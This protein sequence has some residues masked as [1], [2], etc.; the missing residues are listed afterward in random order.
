MESASAGLENRW[1]SWIRRVNA[2]PEQNVHPRGSIKIASL[3]FNISNTKQISQPNHWFPGFL[4]QN[5]PCYSK[6]LSPQG[7][8]TLIW[9]H[10]QTVSNKDFSSTVMC[11]NTTVCSTLNCELA[12]QEQISK[13]FFWGGGVN[14]I[15]ESPFSLNA[16]WYARGPAGVPRVGSGSF[17]LG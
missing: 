5:L 6:V 15:P 14:K 4:C 1:I 8:S 17:R 3:F 7:L 12:H 10:S 13:Y 16:N 11:E 9:I 2:G